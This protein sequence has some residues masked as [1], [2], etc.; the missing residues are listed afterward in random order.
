VRLKCPAGSTECRP[1]PPVTDDDGCDLSLAWWFT[2]DAHAEAVKR[3]QAP[4]R[5]A[6]ALVPA[7][8]RDILR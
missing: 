6:G 7:R 4:H 8:C 1:Q 2:D 3:R 5:L